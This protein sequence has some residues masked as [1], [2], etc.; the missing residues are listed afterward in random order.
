MPNH[1]DEQ[2][3]PRRSK[4]VSDRLTFLARF[5]CLIDIETALWPTQ[6]QIPA[7]SFIHLTKLRAPANVVEHLLSRPSSLPAIR[8]IGVLWKAPIHPHLMTLIHFL[9]SITR[10]L[11][12]RRLTPELS[13]W[14]KSLS[15]YEE[16]T[17]LRELS[18]VQLKPLARIERLHL[19]DVIPGDS[20][21]FLEPVVSTFRGLKHVSV[22]TYVFEDSVL[23]L[24]QE[25][26]ATDDLKSIEVDGKRYDLTSH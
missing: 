12:R 17:V 23:Q 26:R 14:I 9:L 4:H 24:V 16:T 15:G 2:H 22:T 3:A 25:V 7:S 6:D 1:Y 13:L 21:P 18:D 20:R 8:A 11:A 10:T 5:P 19:E